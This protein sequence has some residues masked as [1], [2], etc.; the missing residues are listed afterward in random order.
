[1]K[2]TRKC[3][4]LLLAAAIAL[5]VAGC[6]G[7]GAGGGQPGI[8]PTQGSDSPVTGADPG[9]NPGAGVEAADLMSGVKGASVAVKQSDKRFVGAMADFS[10]ELF[11]KSVADSGNTLV[12]PLS[13]MLALAMTANG[14]DGNTLAQMETLLG[15][16]IPIA[17]L[18]AYLRGYT[19]N[20]PSADKS[21]LGLANSIWFRDDDGR[22][23][24]NPDFL[25]TN[26]DYY[27]A[28]AYAAPFDAQTV[29]DINNWVSDNTDGMIEKIIDEIG[30]DTIMYL[31]NAVVF[32]AE[33]QRVYDK[34]ELRKGIF[35]DI[36]GAER[37]V[38]FMRSEEFAYIEDGKATGFVK[39]YAGGAYSFAALLPD[40]GVSIEAYVQSLT[41]A[42]LLDTLGN[43]EAAT[44]FVSLP[45]F[46]YDYELE[47]SDALKDLG[48]T[49]AFDGGLA[50]FGRMASS[51]R[52]NIFI[53]SVI[54]K[55]FISVD[56]LGTKAGAVSAIVMA[57]D[58]A[59]F[60]QKVVTLDRPFVYAILDNATNLP[61]FI[62]VFAMP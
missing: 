46:G 10:V 6:A 44:V 49:D 2:H 19:D 25:Q 28:S 45:K 8:P 60:Y 47:M 26:A 5:S 52:G 14:A 3:L 42:S 23:Q 48:M 43:Q 56:E 32:D 51:S 15:G 59:P 21:K 4:L 20:L 1:M 13:V 61:I 18:G 37:Q 11:K 50:D 29:K 55:T 34:V 16:G 7:A 38:E 12:S 40:E 62:G 54:H 30:G 24:V 36:T 17:E 39:P 41:G 58:A 27:G 35:H 31:I 9:A 22:L 33:W 57:D 53:G